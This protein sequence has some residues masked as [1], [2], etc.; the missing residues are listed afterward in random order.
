MFMMSVYSVVIVGSAWL[1]GW[2]GAR[3]LARFAKQIGF[4]PRYAQAAMTIS[5]LAFLTVVSVAAGVLIAAI[6]GALAWL[7][8]RS[9]WV[10]L[11]VM[12]LLATVGVWESPGAW[13]AEVPEIGFLLLAAVIFGVSVFAARTAELPLPVLGGVTGAA[14]LPL[15][16]APFVFP[17]AHSSLALDAAIILAALVAGIMALPKS[18]MAAPFL[19]LPLAVLVAY[20]ATQAMHYGAWPLGIVS[21]LIWLAGLKLAP[22]SMQAAA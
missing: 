11:L 9:S 13:P 14:C 4:D 7:V 15:L 12:V 1:A 19:R 8:T 2:I 3:T 6:V 16:I 18:A 17:A 10:P 21:L 5:M 20:G 22:R